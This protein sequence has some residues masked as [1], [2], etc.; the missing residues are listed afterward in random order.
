LAAFLIQ[1]GKQARPSAFG[2]AAFA[3]VLAL[4]AGCGGGGYSSPPPPPPSGGTTP[5]AYAVTVYAFT[6]SN[7]SDGTNAHADASVQIPLTVN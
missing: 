4:V 1:R 7:M 3:L 5:G 2:L 6:E